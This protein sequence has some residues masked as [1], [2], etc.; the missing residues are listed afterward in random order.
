MCTVRGD[1]P[2][3][4]GSSIQDQGGGA[5]CAPARAAPSS[6]RRGRIQHLP[7]PVGRRL[8]RPP[9]RQRHLGAL[10]GATS[11]DG[12]RRRVLRRLAQLLPPRASGA[13]PLRLPPR[14][15]GASGT[16]RGAPAFTS[17]RPSRSARA[18]EPVLHDLARARRAPRR[19]LAGRR[20]R[21]GEP[22]RAR[23][24]RSRETS[25]S[26][27]WR[28]RFAAMAATGLHSSA[29]RP[30]STWRAGSRS[31]SRTSRPSAS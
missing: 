7:A 21:R 19:S 11:G 17:A 23:T 3:T 16:R 9:H 26:T 25:T 13:R 20:L 5:D 30:A 22:I 2:E 27:N 18:L 8:H 6:A 31:P 10:P 4:D 24:S 12:A 29:R 14:N 1:H 15:P 28:T